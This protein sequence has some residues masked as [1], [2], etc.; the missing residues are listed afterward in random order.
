MI[1]IELLIVVPSLIVGLAWLACAVLTA[2]LAS[3]TGR[4]VIGWGV[5]AVVLGPFALTALAVLPPGEG[6]KSPHG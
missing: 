6:G 2:R 5:L 3:Q 1:L 4:H